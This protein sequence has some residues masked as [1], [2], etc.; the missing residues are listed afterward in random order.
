MWGYRNGN[1]RQVILSSSTSQQH[2]TWPLDLIRL[3][4][5]VNNPT[6]HLSTLA[7]SFGDLPEYGAG[8]TRMLLKS[9]KIQS[10]PILLAA[11]K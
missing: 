11:K 8:R 4:V 6:G 7:G 2:E 9:N 3:E 1:R 10:S 5:S